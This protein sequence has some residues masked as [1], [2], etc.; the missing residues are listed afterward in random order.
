VRDVSSRFGTISPQS[1]ENLHL[2][3]RQDTKSTPS[4][5]HATGRM[6]TSGVSRFVDRYRQDEFLRRNV[7]TSAAGGKDSKVIEGDVIV[8]T[9]NADTARAANGRRAAT[10]AMRSATVFAPLTAVSLAALFLG[11]CGSGTGGLLGAAEGSTQPETNIATGSAPTVAQSSAPLPAAKPAGPKVA[12]APVIGAPDGVA[13][14]MHQDLSAA[15][16][17]NGMVV[18]KSN[19]EKSDYTLRGYVVAAK[20]KDKTKL[21]YI[22]DVIDPSGQRVNR[23]TG[24][25]LAPASASKDNWASVTPAVSQAVS[26]KSATSLAAWIPKGATAGKSATSGTPVASATAP[27]AQPISVGSTT[28]L[29]TQTTSTAGAP[30]LKPQVGATPANGMETV[31]AVVPQIVGAPGDGSTSLTGAIQRELSR[32][33][34][35]LATVP[36]AATYRVEGKVVL[37]QSVDGKQPI[38]IDWTVKDPKGKN[39][40]TVSQKNEVQEGSLDG[41]W[42]KTADA[43]AA[44]AAQ[45]VLKLLPQKTA[46]AQ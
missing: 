7:R 18:A 20:E 9:N 33:G 25:E 24:D 6:G 19:D 13:K 31:F 36:S 1:V 14:Q 40:G 2:L 29:A 17:K 45:G 43:A 30:A 23:I 11:G 5:R 44:A 34:V 38:Q 42:G 12:I 32:G 16:E 22:W 10:V 4:G 27:T 46:S 3:S 26:Q 8:T 37:G 21:S 28:P 15:I 35:M 39:L 41:A